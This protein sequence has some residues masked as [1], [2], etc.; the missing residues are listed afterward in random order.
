ML[1]VVFFAP[2]RL[3]NGVPAPNPS[4]NGT[5]AESKVGKR[6]SAPYS[7]AYWFAWNAS[8]DFMKYVRMSI[9]SGN[10]MVEFFS[11]EIVFSVWR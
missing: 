9:G 10:T 1:S 7:R 6:R 3:G 4:K 8:F 5:S 11:A 2:V